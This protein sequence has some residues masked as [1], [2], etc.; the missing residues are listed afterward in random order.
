MAASFQSPTSRLRR[1][2][3]ADA[4]LPSRVFL[5]SIAL[6]G[7]SSVACSDAAKTSRGPEVVRAAEGPASI[8]EGGDARVPLAVRAESKLR[9]EVISS[10]ELDVEVS[11]DDDDASSQGRE[12]PVTVALHARYGDATKRRAR[13]RI[14]DAEGR[15]VETEVEAD[16][17]RLGFGERV[18]WGNEGPE[19]REHGAFV[20]DA[21]RDR[22]VLLGGS[23]Y[24]P[25]L[26]P[27]SD[28]WAFSLR[29]RRWTRLTPT[30]DPLPA[31]GSRRLAQ[32]DPQT[33]YLFGGY[34]EQG[35]PDDILLRVDL[36][37]EQPRI[38]RIAHEGGPGAR[39]L[40]AFAYDAVSR[41]FVVF[42]G[43]SSIVLRDTWLLT[44]E[45]DA[46][47]W[48]KLAVQ[49]P[50]GRY[51]FFYGFD[52]KARR[53]IVW[54]GATGTRTID[55]AT[56]AW[57]LDMASSPPAWQLVAENDPNTPSGRRNGCF[58]FDP[59]SSRLFVTGGTPDARTSSPGFF[60]LDTRPGKEA[61][62]KLER[63][64]EPPLR[65]S[66]FGYWDDARTQAVC[67]FGNTV[68]DVFSDLTPFGL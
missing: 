37:D 9:F 62:T 47:R 39:S 38:T 51:G 60:V 8:V 12:R 50:K 27:L 29:D 33:A 28:A 22:V 30:G 48:E 56:D 44:V 40:H 55:P 46:A 59:T 63:P 68:Q 45:G 1:R 66:G 25:Y 67:G 42:A 65:S 54:S 20:L 3:A 24:S 4:R 19:P 26:A 36:R 16:V 15:A 11:A 21:A 35:E 64:G 5:V 53:L 18:R 7:A 32:V 61:W 13:I 10:E 58:V 49:G 2:P 34:G 41:R 43:V 23:G 6:V 14:L 57:A 17:R 31:G 52:P